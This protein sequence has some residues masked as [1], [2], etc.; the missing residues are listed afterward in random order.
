MP[1]YLGQTDSLSDMIQGVN[2]ASAGGGIIFASGSELVQGFPPVSHKLNVLLLMGR[3]LH[4]FC[5]F[6]ILLSG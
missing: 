3:I 4:I 6:R 1:S 2:Y 5:S